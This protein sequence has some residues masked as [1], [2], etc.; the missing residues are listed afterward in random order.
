M[1]A[2]G[3]G[4]VAGKLVTAGADVGGG[5]NGVSAGGVAGDKLKLRR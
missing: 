2:A 1:V 5:V 3:C 4:W